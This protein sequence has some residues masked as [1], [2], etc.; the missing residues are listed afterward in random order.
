MN[1]FTRLFRRKPKE[2]R[3]ITQA[4]VEDLQREHSE[5]FGGQSPTTAD[6]P[7]KPEPGDDLIG[8]EFGNHN[9]A[10]N[11]VHVFRQPFGYPI[12][13]CDWVAVDREKLFI[14]CHTQ[15]P[16]GPAD[17]E[18]TKRAL[19]YEAMNL[20]KKGGRPICKSCQAIVDGNRSSIGQD[21]HGNGTGAPLP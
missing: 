20:Q 17:V 11:R 7:P 21:N 1:W 16:T 8:R 4:D 3:P 18:M 10:R 15:G 2:E 12:R 9:E 14:F 6:T 19:E 13:L 5:Y